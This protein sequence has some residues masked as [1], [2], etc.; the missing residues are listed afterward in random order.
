MI[1]HPR[2]GQR[3]RIHYARAKAPLMPHHGRTGVVRL[4]P[5]GRGP[6]NVGVDVGGR[7]VAVP[8]GN[9]IALKTPEDTGA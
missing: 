7:I 5:R 9:L 2:V 3:V 4:A 6:R 8:R 1:F